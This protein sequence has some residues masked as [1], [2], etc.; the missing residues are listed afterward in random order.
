MI[1]PALI[2]A[3]KKQLARH[4]TAMQ[5]KNLPEDDQQLLRMYP[6]HTLAAA[7]MIES[8][9]AARPP[10]PGHVIHD[11][12]EDFMVLQRQNGERKEDA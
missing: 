9:Q 3:A 1:D 5:N 10:R 8:A 4:Q 6:K 12:G 7:R 11:A 2:A